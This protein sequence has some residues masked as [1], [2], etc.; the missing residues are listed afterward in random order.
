MSTITQAWDSLTA[1]QMR[2]RGSLKW[3]R[4]PGTIGAW[5]AE[6][7]LGIAPEVA[8]AIKQAVDVGELGYMP[9]G[10]LTECE[11]ALAAYSRR[12]Y[13]WDLDP[14]KIFVVHDVIMRCAEF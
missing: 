13:G 5:V 9:D 12:N 8:E 4:W 14:D 7:D 11:R 1:Q 6:M 2:E 3:T 10:L